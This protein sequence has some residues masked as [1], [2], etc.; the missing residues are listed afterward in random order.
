MS[1]TIRFIVEFIS[2][3]TYKIGSTLSISTLQVKKKPLYKKEINKIVPNTDYSYVLGILDRC[4]KICGT[5]YIFNK[6]RW[7]TT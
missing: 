1:Y 7:K 3:D 5:Q 4:C 2:T 6:N